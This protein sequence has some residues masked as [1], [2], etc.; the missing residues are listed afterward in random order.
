MATTQQILD[1]EFGMLIDELVKAYDKKGMRASGE[2]ENELE[3]VI[4]DSKG[5]LLGAPH[6]GALEFGRSPST[7]GSKPGKLIDAIKQWIID[8][9]IVSDIKDDTDNSSLAF[10]ITRKIHREGWR[11][12]DHGGVELISQVITDKRMQQIINRIG[13]ALTLELVTKIEKEFKQIAV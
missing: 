4:T 3:K 11:R 12:K 5:T 10:L 1:E 7:T 6:S 13:N 2:F 9:G 8:K